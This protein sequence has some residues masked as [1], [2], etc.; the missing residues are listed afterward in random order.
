MVYGAKTITALGLILA[1]S[2]GALSL[3]PVAFLEELGIAFII[4]LLIDTFLI[5]TFY[6]PAMLTLFHKFGDKEA[7]NL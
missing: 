3:I 2:L 1:F 5:R 7:D 4:S 6:F